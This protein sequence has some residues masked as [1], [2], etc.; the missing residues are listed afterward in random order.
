MAGGVESAWER[1]RLLL[2]LGT[3]G[4]GNGCMRRRSSAPS[5]LDDPRLT[6]LPPLAP[7]APASYLHYIRRQNPLPPIPPSAST[8]PSAYLSA[9]LSITQAYEFALSHVGLDPLSAPIWREYLAFVREGETRSQWEEQGK[10]SEYR[11]VV[12]R[13]VRVPMDGLED[14]WRE[15]D[16]FE[17][18][19]NRVTVRS[20]FLSVLSRA[21]GRP[22]A[23]D[24][25]PPCASPQAKKFLAERS[26]TYMTSRTL[27]KE[28]RARL[29]PAALAVPPAPPTRPT[30]ATPADHAVVHAWR[31]YVDWERSNPCGFEGDDVGECKKR[32]GYALRRCVGG[33][34]RF[35]PELWV[36]AAEWE[37][38][39]DRIDEAAA[40]LR[41]GLEAIPTR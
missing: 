33:E 18:Q 8:L 16:Q 7:S 40:F 30:W 2:L 31:A 15:Y 5:L 12:G 22:K 23:D 35:Y 19:V 9:R 11:G 39:E 17:G 25:P 38:S 26:P 32:V 21:R 3:G 14:I 29:P 27:L 36:L 34:G 13:A 41:A 6:P 4:G 20:R 10:V 37:R 1:G 28:V 24:P